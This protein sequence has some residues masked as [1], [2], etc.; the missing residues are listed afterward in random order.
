VKIHHRK[1]GK[2]KALR[3]SAGEYKIIGQGKSTRL[4][5]KLGYLVRH[6]TGKEVGPPHGR[7]EENPQTGEEEKGKR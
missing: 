4:M 7:K 5:S 3:P 6:K 1:R 2:G